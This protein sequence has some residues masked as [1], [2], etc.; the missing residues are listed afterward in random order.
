MTVKNV[1]SLHSKHNYDLLRLK[2]IAPVTRAWRYVEL[3]CLIQ[4][5]VLARHGVFSHNSP[6]NRDVNSYTIRGPAVVHGTVVTPGG[7]LLWLS[8]IEFNGCIYTRNRR[9]KDCTLICTLGLCL[10]IKL[11]V[12]ALLCGIT[13]FVFNMHNEDSCAVGAALYHSNCLADEI[14]KTMKFQSCFQVH[15]AL[16]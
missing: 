7:S 5:F 6:V 11:D 3:V 4:I 14:I 2:F 12:C 15:F 13:C 9:K 8:L 16:N 1:R 10:I